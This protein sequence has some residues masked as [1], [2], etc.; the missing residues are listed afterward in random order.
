[1]VKYEKK[2]SDAKAHRSFFVL[3]KVLSSQLHAYSR[4][5]RVSLGRS[6]L[7][8]SAHL[9]HGSFRLKVRSPLTRLV[10]L[11]FH[12]MQ[13]R[14]ELSHHHVCMLLVLCILFHMNDPLLEFVDVLLYGGRIFCGFGF[15][16]R[17]GEKTVCVIQK[18][19]IQ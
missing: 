4:Q 1:M 6:F 9:V 3:I 17:F 19:D 7:N 14:L 5:V 10:N 12:R 11:K 8:G 13:L 18:K 15:G 16:R 2:N